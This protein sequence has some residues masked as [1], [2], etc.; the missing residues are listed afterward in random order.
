MVSDAVVFTLTG[1]ALYGVGLGI[2]A[3]R[4]LAVALLLLLVFSVATALLYVAG[5]V[6]IR[7]QAL[8]EVAELLVKVGGPPLTARV[9]V[10]AVPVVLGFA[11]GYRL[12]EKL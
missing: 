9:V 12:G 10:T 6:D 3:S 5:V 7:T 4:R 8:D 1:L 2:I 11:L